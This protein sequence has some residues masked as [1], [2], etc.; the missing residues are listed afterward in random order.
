MGALQRTS[1]H[2]YALPGGSK[3]QVQRL[4]AGLKS[5]W[6]TLNSD[7][8]EV[9]TFETDVVMGRCALSTKYSKIEAL[10]AHRVLDAETVNDSMCENAV[11]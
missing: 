11:R 4:E 5:N 8:G 7:L 1:A 6:R 9:A 3:R 2:L 10:S